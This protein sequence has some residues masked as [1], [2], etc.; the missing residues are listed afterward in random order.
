MLIHIHC[1]LLLQEFQLI[2]GTIAEWLVM[3]SLVCAVLDFHKPRIHL[4]VLYLLEIK[5]IPWS[6]FVNNSRLQIV[7]MDCKSELLCE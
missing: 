4:W 6:S 2:P 7:L 1:Q 3:L 5:L